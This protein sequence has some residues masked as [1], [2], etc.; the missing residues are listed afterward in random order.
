MAADIAVS[1]DGAKVFVTGYACG[2]GGRDVV[3]VAY[4]STTGAEIWVARYDG[5]TNGSDSGQA[6][7]VSPD[8]EAVYVIGGSTGNG[9]GRDFVTLKLDA[10]DGSV[11]WLARYDGPAS[12]LDVGADVVVSPDG[13]GIIVTG[14]S[15][16]ISSAHDYAT[17][18]YD[19]ATGLPAWIQRLD[20][21]AGA[22]SPTGI[23]RNA[24]GTLVFVTGISDG[25]GTS[26]DYLTVAYRAATGA[27]EWTARHDGP[28]SSF[29]FSLGIAAAAGRIFVTGQ[30]AGGGTNWDYATIAY[31]ETNGTKL[32][33]S[34]INTPPSGVDGGLAVAAPASGGSVFVT[35]RA[36]GAMLTV[37]YNASTGAELWRDSHGAARGDAIDI[38]SD[39]AL[40]LVAGSADGIDTHATVGSPQADM[41]FRTIDAA[42]GLAVSTFR[43]NGPTSDHEYG[44]SVARTPGD[45]RFFATGVTQLQGLTVGTNSGWDFATIAYDL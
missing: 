9:T 36:A 26:L 23:A 4:N 45:E 2:N 33:E 39:D 27:L 24:N 42:S 20:G 8:G 13:F 19:A 38:T 15:Q 14:S 40:V 3:T 7:G 44:L 18:R 32:W 37:S 43:Y 25:G 30:D 11:Q 35:G 28:G 6:L 29:D 31:A 5:P 1:P 21:P 10:E 12:A 16:G 17:I 41:L 34:R 22:D